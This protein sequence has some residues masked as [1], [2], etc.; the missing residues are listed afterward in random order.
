MDLCNKCAGFSAICR[1]ESW[2]SEDSDLSQ[3]HIPN[4]NIINQGTNCSGDG[5]LIIYVHERYQY[6]I[7]NLYESSAIWKGLFLDNYGANL[8]EH[9]TIGNIY[10]PPKLNNTDIVFYINFY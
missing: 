5:G 8:K 4:H 9:I 6:N 1:H 3:Y 10:R 2:L 7:R